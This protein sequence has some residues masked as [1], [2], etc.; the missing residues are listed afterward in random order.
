MSL[1]FPEAAV[2]QPNGGYTLEFAPT[3]RSVGFL[4]MRPN[5][6]AAT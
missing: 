6:D 1:N 2:R 5:L 3:T 4:E